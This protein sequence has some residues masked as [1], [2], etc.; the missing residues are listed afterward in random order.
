MTELET[1]VGI[2][3]E[4]Q[5]GSYFHWLIPPHR[6]LKFPGAQG[7]H[8]LGRHVGRS[9]F[10][11]AHVL[12]ISSRIDRALHHHEGPWQV[13]RQIGANFDRTSERPAERMA[14]RGLIRKF[15]YYRAQRSIDVASVLFS[16]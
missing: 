5:N 2:D 16:V 14:G 13:L 6:W 10:Q 11:Y 12:Q 8:N 3:V 7:R 1:V 4:S 9:R 15:H